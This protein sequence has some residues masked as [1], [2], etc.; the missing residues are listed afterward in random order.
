MLKLLLWTKGVEWVKVLNALGLLCLW[1]CIKTNPQTIFFWDCH[2]NTL[3][4]SL[5]S[6]TCE[7]CI[8]FWKM[9]T[10]RTLRA[11][12]FTVTFYL[13]I[14]EIPI[15]FE[16]K[17]VETDNKTF[18]RPNLSRPRLRLFWD[19]NFRGQ[20]QGGGCVYPCKYTYEHAFPN[21]FGKGHCAF[22]Q[23]QDI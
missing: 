11:I 18:L 14:C 16:I 4:K 22:Y 8:S 12:D 23:P 10:A 1:Q 7:L 13:G 6:I 17:T 21:N 5:Q 2:W 20:D 15:F 3:W 9:I 19:Q